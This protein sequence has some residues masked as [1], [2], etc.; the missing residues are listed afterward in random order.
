MKKLVVLVSFLLSSCTQLSVKDEAGKPFAL[1]PD[2]VSFSVMTYNVENLF[3]LKDDPKKEDNTFLPLSLKK[4]KSHISRCQEIEVKKWRDQC[5]ELDWNDKVLNTKLERLAQV[6]RSGGQE[7][8][9]ADLLIFQEIEN[10]AILSKLRDGYLADLGYQSLILIE[11]RDERGIDVAFLSRFPVVGQPKL[12]SIT[13]PGV[14][15]KR[16]QD[17]RGILEAT[18]RLPDNRLLNAYAVH[19]PA[20][21]HPAPMRVQAFKKLN[22]IVSKL[23][24]ERLHIAGG[25]FNLTA[26]EDSRDKVLDRL[27]KKNWVVAHQMGCEDCKGTNYYPPKDSWSFL[28]MILFSKNFNGSPWKFREVKIINRL[29]FQKNKKNEPDGVSDHWPIQV[30]FTQKLSV[31]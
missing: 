17:T 5:L 3:D 30:I 27:V 14:E 8:R 31:I 11:G 28:D 21:F 29:P 18:F 10:K 16:V 20:P 7:K 26:E 19:F 1:A 23:P 12:H 4:S 6:I 13:F 9:G 2:E 25:D 24:P 15:E 22:E